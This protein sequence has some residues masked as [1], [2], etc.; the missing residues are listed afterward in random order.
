ML[1]WT[2][3]VC[4]IKVCLRGAW[5]VVG[6]KDQAHKYHGKDGILRPIRKSLQLVWFR[7]VQRKR[8]WLLVKRDV[9]KVKELASADLHEYPF[10]CNSKKTSF[11]EATS[12]ALK[13]INSWLYFS[14]KKLQI[15]KRKGNAQVWKGGVCRATSPK[16]PTTGEKKKKKQT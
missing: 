4:A 15:S 10:L 5:Y 8:S 7:V 2:K 9:N 12:W 16:L 1:K 3:G 13:I 11:S 14:T 6:T